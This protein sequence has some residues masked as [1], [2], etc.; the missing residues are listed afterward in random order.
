MRTCE[1]AQ[2]AWYMGGVLHSG[3]GADLLD[4][5]DTTRENALSTRT[6]EW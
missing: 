2:D 1:V 4:H 6:G 3:A 5:W